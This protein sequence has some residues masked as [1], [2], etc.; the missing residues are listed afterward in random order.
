MRT[1]G[2]KKNKGF[3]LIEV[4]VIVAIIAIL[5]TGIGLSYSRVSRAGV[6]TAAQEIKSLTSECR[7]AQMSRAGTYV[8]DIFID[9][10]DGCVHGRL[11]K[12]GSTDISAIASSEKKF[13]RVGV[14]LDIV[15]PDGLG[16]TDTKT[17]S[18]GEHLYISFKRSSG[19]LQTC[20]ISSGSL[21]WTTDIGSFSS[22]DDVII[23]V[24]QGDYVYDV[25]IHSLTG[26]QEMKR[27][28]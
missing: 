22:T 27:V 28:S 20:K 2:R 26:S 18:S 8:A 23:K 5:G 9:S 19:R 6:K 13:A 7:V 11:L 21:N 16:G 10:S 25:T 24:Y 14:S 17:L 15:I 12:E 1:F 3:T 4:I